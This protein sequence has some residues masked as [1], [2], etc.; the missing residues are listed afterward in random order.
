[1]EGER[2]DFP[3]L[4]VHREDSQNGETTKGNPA[5]FDLWSQMGCRGWSY[6]EVWPFFKK[7]ERYDG[8]SDEIRG[9]DGPLRVEDYRTI[10]PLTH[11]SEATMVRS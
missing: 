11:H 1:M 7:S 3:R 6:D 10:L 5:D 9:R 8:G 2:V 4:L